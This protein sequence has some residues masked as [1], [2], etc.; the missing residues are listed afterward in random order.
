MENQEKPLILIV[1][2]DLF[3]MDFTHE[4]LSEH[5]RV[6]TAESGNEALAIA[7]EAHPQLILTDVLMPEIN[8]YE[9]CRMIKDDFDISD[10]PVLFLSAL[11]GIEDRLQGFEAGGEDFVIKPVNPKVLLAKVAQVFKLIEERQQLKSQAQYA[12]NT[13]LLAMTS[14]SETGQV[15]EGFKRFNQATT[16]LELAQAMQAALALFDVESVVELLLPGAKSLA[17]NKNG[18]ATELEISVLKHLAGMDRITHFKTRMAITYP[19]VRALI[20]N[21]PVEDPDRCGRLRDHLAMLVE[22]A[23]VRLESI[24]IAT[25]MARRNAV[26]ADTIKSLSITLNNIDTMQRNGHANAALILNDVKF[27]IDGALA[28]LGLSERQENA[29]IGITQ[30][31]LENISNTLLAEAHFQDQLSATINE[32][33]KA[34]DSD[35]N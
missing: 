10:T 17:L 23:E 2:D 20:C 13:A 24:N 22:A 5:Y 8:G 1:D 11:D 9:L 27:R 26:I 6:I 16:Q 15:F 32:L 30:D 18:P 12:T 34:I 33:Q 7:R 14:M 35:Q 21:M 3:M 29:I 25:Q 4:A 19:H 28:G 31:G